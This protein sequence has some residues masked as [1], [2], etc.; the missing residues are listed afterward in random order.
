MM[1]YKQGLAE[2][3]EGRSRRVRF[4]E[5]HDEDRLAAAFPTEAFRSTAVLHAASPGM[6]LFHHGQLEGL[7]T[8]LPVQL[9]REPDEETDPDVSS[10][11]GKLLGVTK[12]PIFKQGEAF[13]LTV[14]PAFGGDEGFRPL[15][16]FAYRY[17]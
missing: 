11:Y 9:G 10:F 4:L 12:E 3:G 7:K 15:V 6:R 5:N 1:G 2:E 13:V 14:T 17:G 16:G 8:R